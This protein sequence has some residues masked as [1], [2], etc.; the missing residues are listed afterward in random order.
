MRIV[1]VKDV[2]LGEGRPKI[3]V[4][5]AATTAEDALGVAR[6]LSHEAA[7]DIIE[8]RVD[9]LDIASEPLRLARLTR[10]VAEAAPGKP[11]LVTFR[12]QAEGGAAAIPD[13][14]YER[15]YLAVLEE[16]RADLIDVELMRTTGVVRRLVAAAHRMGVPV[17]MSNHDFVA[18]APEEE[19]VAR[20]R[21][22]QELDA[23]VLK[24]ATMPR[25][26]GDVLK[27][28]SATWTM[29][30][31]YAERPLITMA[32]GGKGVLS[33]LAGELFGSAATFGMVGIP[34]APGQMALLDLKATL[35]LI[36]RSM[37]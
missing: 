1:R 16:G 2:V 36:S 21:R 5:I 8:F 19:L 17:V 18:T 27:L 31:R 6:R 29:Y 10:A 11:L 12:T 4:P 13:D 23:D 30:S 28:L 14:A 34:S 33:R 37:T 7:L 15:F 25:D 22:M 24:I 20:M 26:A 32:M 35:D 3:L 9:Y